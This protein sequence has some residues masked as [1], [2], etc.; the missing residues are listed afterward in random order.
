MGIN[1]FKTYNLQ[2]INGKFTVFFF[3]FDKIDK[4]FNMTLKKIRKEEFICI[5][6]VVEKK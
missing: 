6:E 5:A 1:V 4:S 3:F 2:F